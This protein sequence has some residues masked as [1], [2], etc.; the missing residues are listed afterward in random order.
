MTDFNLRLLGA[1]E[2]WWCLVVV[3]RRRRRRCCGG[4]LTRVSGDAIRA[5]HWEKPYGGAGEE[6]RSCRACCCC[7]WCFRRWFGRLWARKRLLIIES[8]LIPKSESHRLGR[9]RLKRR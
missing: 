5:V 1:T 8:A 6:Q 9:S 3:V 7:C 2:S 4:L